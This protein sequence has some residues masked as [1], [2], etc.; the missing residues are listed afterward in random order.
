MRKR[1][2]MLFI[3]IGLLFS[4]ACGTSRNYIIYTKDG[5]KYIASGKPEY[6]MTMVVFENADGQMEYLQK[7]DIDKVV[8][9]KK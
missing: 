6:G 1:L 4:V 9:Q 5:K 3:C 7:S 2:F 8:E